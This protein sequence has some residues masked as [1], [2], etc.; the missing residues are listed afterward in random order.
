MSSEDPALSE[1]ETTEETSPPEPTILSSRERRILGVLLEKA[2]TTPSN[3][4]LTV[5]ALVTG[6]NQ[7]SNR[8]PLSDYDDDDIEPTLEQMEEKG[9][10]KTIYPQ[11]GYTLRYRHCMRQKYDFSEAQLAIMTELLLRGRQTQGELRQRASRMV[12]ISS[13]NELRN[14]L[15]GLIEKGDVQ[16]SDSLEKRGVEVDHTWYLAT[17]NKSFGNSHPGANSTRSQHVATPAQPTTSQTESPAASES[18]RT[19]SAQVSSSTS[20]PN[21]INDQ[22]PSHL[23][24]IQHELATLKAQ[25]EQLQ[26]TNQELREELRELR[27]DLDTVR[28]MVED[29]RRDLGC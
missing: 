27:E 26:L 21:P 12:P 4:P 28:R 1:H 22:I 2:F 19:S 5:N 17:E 20:L 23:E 8:N 18:V 6:C 11:S 3:Y 29:L 25:K 13:L 10:T 7:K 9:F 16:A 14:E 15:K 24:D